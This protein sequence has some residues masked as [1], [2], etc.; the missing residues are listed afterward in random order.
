[1]TL[2]ERHSPYKCVC[3]RACGLGGW[4]G[5]GSIKGVLFS[6]SVWKESLL[7]LK[8]TLLRG[9]VMGMDLG[10]Q[11]RTLMRHRLIMR[12]IIE[13]IQFFYCGV[14]IFI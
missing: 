12:Q 9:N 6:E 3:L 4:E 8:A 7:N 11:I 5:G 1:M 10:K 13:H 14:Y 2:E